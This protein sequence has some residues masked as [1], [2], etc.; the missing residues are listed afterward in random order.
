VQNR[1]ARPLRQWKEYATMLITIP[2]V[3][4]A[5]QVAHARKMLAEADWVDGRAT[6]G[7]QSALAKD[8]MQITLSRSSWA[9]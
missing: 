4:D 8:N 5:A 2:N 6:A 1:T 9:T 3:L 7:Y